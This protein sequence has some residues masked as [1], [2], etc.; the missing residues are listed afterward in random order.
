[1]LEK[2]L[3]I[4]FH[5]IKPIFSHLILTQMKIRQLS[6]QLPCKVKV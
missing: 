4:Y 2:F 3:K 5:P 1:M 6:L